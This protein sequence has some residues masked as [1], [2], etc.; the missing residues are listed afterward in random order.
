MRPGR[1]QHRHLTRLVDDGHSVLSPGVCV[2]LAGSSGAASAD[3]G[4][5]R[6]GDGAK[7]REQVIGAQRGG[8]AALEEAMD[9]GQPERCVVTVDDQGGHLH[10]VAV[11][12]ARGLARPGVRGSGCEPVVPVRDEDR[13]APEVRQRQLGIR[14]GHVRHGDRHLA[15][16]DREQRPGG[17]GRGG[18]CQASPGVGEEHGLPVD[19][20]AAQRSDP[21]CHRVRVDGLVGQQSRGWQ[22]L[23]DGDTQCDGPDRSHRGLH[24]HQVHARVTHEISAPAGP[25][26]AEAGHALGAGMKEPEGVHPQ[27][28]ATHGRIVRFD[29]RGC[30]HPCR[31]SGGRSVTDQV[32][33]SAGPNG[34]T[35]GLYEWLQRGSELLARG[36]AAA[37]ATLLER[38]HAAEPTS[39]SV[40]EA[41]ARARYD[42]GR[43]GAA[44]ETFALL[45]DV[46]PASDY[47]HFGLG[48]S[49]FRLGRVSDAE[50]HLAMAAAMRP[51]RP[52][53]A[54]R[55][56]EVRATRTAREAAGP[57]GGSPAG[58]NRVREPGPDSGPAP[59]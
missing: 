3:G 7:C 53:Y 32:P 40:I 55:L 22:G 20:G 33:P 57:P 44:A 19:A 41:L 26:A 50:P 4:G 34:P 47:A 48:L 6:F 54:R 52:E 49:L 8:G 28:S 15:V 58:G 25:L 56:R 10:A 1:A 23:T 59:A 11:D 9:R 51:E 24:C 43:Y 46:E 5:D 18:H 35:G 31:E 2:L 12:G 29:S 39:A 16:A 30:G 17:S 14:R 21:A 36:D 13:P 45:V 38:A 27:R 37:A 42:S